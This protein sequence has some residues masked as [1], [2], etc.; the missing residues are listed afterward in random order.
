ML[1]W[2]TMQQFKLAFLCFLLFCIHPA[3]ADKQRFDVAALEQLGYSSDVAEFFEKVRFLPGTHTVTV[4]VNAAHSYELDVMFDDNG[5]LCVN[6]TFFDVLKLK[7][8]PLLDA[9]NTPATLWMGAEVKLYPGT[10]RIELLLPEYAFDPLKISGEQY[11]GY[12]A[13]LNYD[14][15]GQRFSSIYGQQKSLQGTIFPGINMLNWVIRN[16]SQFSTSTDQRFRSYETAAIK[17]IPTL[18]A[19]LE[20][21]QF[22]AQN[23]LFAGLPLTGIQLMSDQNQVDGRLLIPFTGIADSQANVEVR[24]RGRT[25]YQTMV[26]PGP[27]SLDNLGHAVSGV[28]T[29]VEITEADG[30]K[31][32]QTLVP[33]RMMNNSSHPLFQLGFGRYRSYR[34]NQSGISPP[35]L[36]VGERKIS[37]RQASDIVMGG[38]FSRKY[39]TIMLRHNHDNLSGAISYSN[40]RQQRGI[41]L[42]TQLQFTPSRQ[43]SFSL[44]SMYR[45]AGAQGA[46]EGLAE[47]NESAGGGMHMALGASLSLS[48]P[49]WGTLAYS[50]SFNRYYQTNS[51]L[52]HALSASHPLGAGALNL[53]LQASANDPLSIFA[54][55]SWPL[56]QNRVS[57]RM[58]AGG[59]RLGSSGVNFQ[60]QPNDYWGYSMDMLNS[61]NN[62][63]LS[64]NI[65]MTTPYNLMTAGMSSNNN[66]SKSINTSSSGSLAYANGTWLASSSKVGDTLAVVDTGG[67]PGIKLQA[68]G[69]GN[70]TTDYAGHALLSSILPYQDNN[71]QIDTQALPLNL[72]LNTTSASLKLAYGTVGWQHFRVTEVKQLLLTIKAIDGSAMPVGASVYDS[73]GGFLGTLMGEGNLMLV[74]EDIGKSLQVRP[75]NAQVCRVEYSVPKVFEPETLY[76]ESEATCIPV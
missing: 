2:P 76:E 6:N 42:D 40:G 34:N 53:T 70:T 45:T 17:A 63:Q 1:V 48:L 18:K 7:P 47:Y 55:I 73:N 19:R 8:L 28:E 41:Q 68:S 74:N 27:F 26:S 66:G 56:G 71:I 37:L 25:V 60:G 5:Q 57:A 13:I 62:T 15:Y 44:T 31:K 36:L 24:Q 54:Y 65:Q 29:E 49:K 21:G 30:R 35:A 20:I 46:D 67:T 22:G 11:G 4:R 43:T 32:V 61:K 64:G 23:T 75:A 50:A 72:H 69:A 9:C 38:I 3:F 52:T 59:N 10:F 12:A 39:Q 14:L 33:Q 58:Q 51:A 16:R